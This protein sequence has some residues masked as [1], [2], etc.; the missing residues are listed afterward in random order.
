VSQ[1]M[2]F[3]EWL[4]Q[5]GFK[6]NPFAEREAER[7]KALPEYFIAG[8]HY[9]DMLGDLHDPRTSILFADRGCGKTAYRL[10]IGQ[11]C[12]PHLDAS[13]VLAAT[14]TRF[15]PLL[16][17]AGNDPAQVS[18][19][20][21]IEGILRSVTVSLLTELGRRPEPFLR[22][23]DDLKGFVKSLV[24]AY[25]P[26]WLYPMALRRQLAKITGDSNA[27]DADI[28]WEKMWQSNEPGH[29]S[30]WLLDTPL[31]RSAVA[32]FWIRLHET[33]ASDISRESLEVLETVLEDIPFLGIDGLYVLVDELDE[34]TELLVPENVAS[35]LEPLLEEWNLLK[36]PGLGMK[37]FLPRAARQALLKCESIRW[38]RLP[39]YMLN[40]DDAL[41]L[42]LLQDRLAA[43][44][45]GT[46]RSL[47]AF[48]EVPDMDKTLVRQSWGRPRT[49]ILLGNLLL[50]HGYERSGGEPVLRSQAL[51]DAIWEFKK[52][53]TSLL[54]HL[55]LDE[56][57]GDV[58]VGSQLVK[59]KITENEFKALQYLY[60]RAG[61]LV[62]KDEMIDAVYGTGARE[63]ITD[64][65]ID[66][67]MSRLR[68]KIEPDPSRPMYLITVRGRGYR[69]EVVRK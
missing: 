44:S 67:M 19:E 5:L 22:A 28:P 23:P 37:F 54:P 65:A 50:R 1:L 25:A 24:K 46:V 43:F 14:Y 27:K 20:D 47:N 4:R 49:L 53:Y 18:L 10:I 26:K 30:T 51:D 34:T 29:L 52:Q 66:A 59:D 15:A 48:S 39:T 6:G 2:S 31:A 7:E 32:R 45:D 11:E 38:D 8:P 62:T 36:L 63:G 56:Q 3:Q 40:W 58:F 42:Q 64:Q 35:F 55:R 60:K 12:K 16:R 69:L 57:A 33:P 21:H 61:E 68:R 13:P 17:R 41:L 9:S